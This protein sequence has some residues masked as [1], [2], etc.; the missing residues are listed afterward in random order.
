[1]SMYNAYVE[2]AHG[3]RCYQVAAMSEDEAKRCASDY[4][5]VRYVCRVAGCACQQGK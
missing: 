1:M 3:M 4:G 2:T 5:R